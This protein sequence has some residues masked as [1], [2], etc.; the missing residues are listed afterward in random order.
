[1]EDTS[2]RAADRAPD[3]KIRR[4]PTASAVLQDGSLLEMVYSRDP[5]RTG[6]VIAKG[7]EHRAVVDHR[8][9]D[10]RTLAPYSPQN[11]LL[12]HDVVLF[13]SGPEDY[14]SKT[15][16]LAA[17]QRFIHQYVDLS[18][19]FEVIAAHY[20]LLSWVHDGFHELPY[21]R[22]TGAPGS[23]KTRFL[24]TVGGLCYKPI[25]ASG[26]STV[27]PLF[28]IL[29]SI[30]GTL[31]LDEADFRFSDEKNDIT[32]ILNNGTVRGFPVLRAEQ[33]A[34]TKEY[35]PHAYHVFGPKIIASRSAFDD[36]GLE[37]RFI[38]EQ[39]GLKR[40]RRDVPISLDH[41]H[42]EESLHLRNQLLLF[43]LQTL[44]TTP[45][46]PE[47]DRSLEPRLVQSFGPL[48]AMIDNPRVTSEVMAML[49]QHQAQLSADR[50]L[51]L[52]G[53]ILEV[54]R[55]LI[56]GTAVPPTMRQIATVFAER[57]SDELQRRPTPHW[58][59]WQIR[60]RLGLLTQRRADGYVIADS[61][62]S[63]LVTLFERYGL[64]APTSPER[65]QSAQ[66]SSA[67][68]I[69]TLPP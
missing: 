23:G 49:R 69:P 3:E 44:T 32:K 53:R 41:R 28:R 58:I 21:L 63:K 2:K 50:G 43:R 35:S 30:R 16:L 7:G 47:V 26:A 14:G 31:V 10:G 45:A 19:L 8:L 61:E 11:N 29:D 60:Q 17:V 25:F 34:A 13:P 22:V 62:G 40:L 1:M 15:E 48:L 24:L 51:D 36:R 56:N 57:H 4:V 54:I 33:N 55:D 42:R 6:F 5:A 27:S 37:S 39:L 59:G 20:V 38:S 65:S 46:P 66:S 18:P 68:A 9:S 12:T 67:P 52:D 64:T